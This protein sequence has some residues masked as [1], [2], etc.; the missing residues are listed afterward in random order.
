MEDFLKLTPH[1]FY[2]R[3]GIKAMAMQKHPVREEASND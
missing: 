3:W 2:L 1:Y